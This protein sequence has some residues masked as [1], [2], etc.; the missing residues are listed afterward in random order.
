MIE[1]TPRMTN[2]IL[3]DAVDLAITLGVN[4]LKLEKKTY[5]LMDTLYLPS[6]FTLEGVQGGSIISMQGVN[7]PVISKKGSISGNTHIKNITIIGDKTQSENDG[8]YFNDYYSSIEN[9]TISNC[10]RHGVYFANGNASS[11]LVENKFKTLVFRD[12]M[13]YAFFSDDGNKC[14]DATLEDILVNGT[15]GVLGG[16]KISSGAGWFIS[17]VH[18]YNFSNVCPFDIRNSYN[19][20]IDNI[21]IENSGSV[22]IGLYQVQQTCN[23]NNVTIMR[24]INMNT[25]IYVNKS[26]ATNFTA[27]VNINNFNI[28]NNVNSDFIM[29]NSDASNVGVNTTNLSMQGTYKPRI[30]MIGDNIKKGASYIEKVQ[31]DGSLYANNAT[32]T[33]NGIKFS[34]YITKKWNGSGEKSITVQLNDL[35]AYSKIPFSISLFSQKWDTQGGQVKYVAHGMISCGDSISSNAITYLELGT[36]TGLTNKPTY[37]IN[38]DTLE[39]TITFTPSTTDGSNQGVLYIQFGY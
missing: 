22:A 2:N 39:L 24:S 38:T 10:G 34:P 26:T 28:V 30:K 29:I 18:I 27:I 33:L 11:T 13:G 35:I 23:I 25:G 14:T 9:C 19:T 37:S 4:K 1:V 12:C 21:Y 8:V 7:K 32:L 36:I 5:N 15:S 6:N 17:K 16:I 31:I 3:Q 20:N